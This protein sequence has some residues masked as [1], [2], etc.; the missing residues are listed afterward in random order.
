MIAIGSTPVAT[1]DSERFHE[2]LLYLMA[3]YYALHL[4]YP[5]CI[6]TLLSVLQTEILQDS[7]HEG[8]STPSYKKAIGEWKSFIETPTI[9]YFVLE[10]C[11]MWYQPFIFLPLNAP[12][13]CLSNGTFPWFAGPYMN[14]S[15]SARDQLPVAQS[16]SN[17]EAKTFL[18]NRSVFEL[19]KSTRFLELTDPK[20]LGWYLSLPV[21]DRKFIQEGGGLLQ[22]LQKHPAL[23]VTRNLV[24][25]RRGLT[26]TNFRTEDPKPL[27]SQA[28]S[29]DLNK[30]RRPTYYCASL[31]NNCGTTLPFNAKMCRL[32]Y[33]P[34]KRP[35]EK[36]HLSEEDRELGLSPNS[37]KEE[38]N[39]CSSSVLGVPGQKWSTQSDA[40]HSLGPVMEESFQSAC[41]SSH[42]AQEI[43]FQQ[44]AQSCQTHLHGQL[45]DEA[46]NEG[47]AMTVYKDPLAQASFSLDVELELHSKTPTRAV[48]GQWQSEPKG[49][50]TADFPDLEKEVL[51][52]Y[53]SFNST[54]L[55]ASC[56]DGSNAS[57]SAGRYR[58]E[59]DL[60]AEGSAEPHGAEDVPAEAE[61]CGAS[62]D[63]TPCCSKCATWT[64]EDRLDDFGNEDSRCG[65]KNEQY[66]SMMEEE[67]TEGGCA[68]WASSRTA[69]L[70]VKGGEIDPEPEVNPTPL[71]GSGATDRS[72]RLNDG[73]TGVHHDPRPGGASFPNSTGM[74]RGSQVNMSQS[75]DVSGDFRASYTSTRATEARQSVASKSS[76][77]EPRHTTQNAAINTDSSPA[78]SCGQ[79]K[80]T[81]TLSASTVEKYVITDVYM[82]DLD[83]FTEEFIKLQHSQDELKELKTKLACSDGE[84]Q[85]GGCEKC[86]CAQR[87]VRAEL[88]LLALQYG[89]CQQH[90]WGRYYTSPEGNCLLRTKAPPQIIKSVLEELE[91]DY[92]EMKK[93]ILS[94]EPLDQLRPISVNS[95]RIVS[96]ALYVPDKIIMDSWSEDE[97]LRT[98]QRGP[99]QL[100]HHDEGEGEGG[101]AP[102][103]RSTESP[104][105]GQIHGA[106]VLRPRPGRAG[107]GLTLQ[108]GPSVGHRRG[109]AKDLDSS[110]AWYDA[111]E[112]I[113]PDKRSLKKESQDGVEEGTFGKGKS[114]HN[115]CFLCVTDLPGDVT[116]DEV[117]LFFKKYQVSEVST[118]TF[119]DGL[120]MAVVKMACPSRAEAAAR[121]LNGHNIRGHAIR[122]TSVRAHIHTSAEP[123][124]GGANPNS[125]PLPGAGCATDAQGP[126]GSRSDTATVTTKPLRH[127]LEKLMN[128]QDS[129]TPSGTCVP[130]HYATMGSFDTLMARLSER[131]PEAE[132]ERIVGA[133][134]ELR[135]QQQGLLSGL[136]LNTIVEMTSDL[137]SRPSTSKAV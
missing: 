73:E 9:V 111:E 79:D 48:C 39:F 127:R 113:G 7:I 33:F 77:T 78:Y 135:A 121:E 86:D 40:E 112:E 130:Q 29:S 11:N 6:S 76:N 123:R 137:L 124:R 85:D 63:S 27:T 20:L 72:G 34:T 129:P 21:E 101:S 128:I 71:Q 5:K 104:Q 95:Q 12:E 32:C 2:G 4:T 61:S 136:P 47:T 69:M 58:R 122:V 19:V 94:G 22:F 80:D 68:A 55:G 116:E 117:T 134:L 65:P 49:E 67:P 64:D 118:T 8:D 26:L 105:R 62:V 110:E 81:Q 25:V 28:M 37:V 23:C 15:F 115:N 46:P 91:A 87:A 13:V 82:A 108:P 66:H 51:P 24:C 38:L 125:G 97:P 31:C 92:R 18:L 114:D 59:Y 30:S 70:Q 17:E 100:A 103:C 120:R 54:G 60:A 43:P 99:Q 89:M 119:S 98:D 50:E 83:Y 44:G 133:L 84:V 10:A 74:A 57:Q 14:Q 109:G 1:F 107:T 3:Y 131:H 93:R 56:E 75:V 88:R 41:D 36:F 90:C 52:D 16:V 132:R 53:Y 102:A 106:P 45:W 35:Q 96:E 126:G 42:S